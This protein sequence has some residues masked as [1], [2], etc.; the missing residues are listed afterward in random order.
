MSTVAI[1]R[2]NVQLLLTHN[3]HEDTSKQSTKHLRGITLADYNSQL[4]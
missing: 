3:E 2:V 1:S 4:I